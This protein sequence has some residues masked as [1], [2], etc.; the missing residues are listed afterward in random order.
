MPSP[1]MLTVMCPNCQH[2]FPAPGCCNPATLQDEEEDESNRLMA[3]E[4]TADYKDFYGGGGGGGGLGFSRGFGHGNSCFINAPTII[5][6]PIFQTGDPNPS[7]KSYLDL[8]RNPPCLLSSPL[9]GETSSATSHVKLS[10][11]GYHMITNGDHTGGGVTIT[12]PRIQSGGCLVECIDSGVL[13]QSPT[14]MRPQ[15]ATE[16]FLS[17]HQLTT[18]IHDF[19]P[20]ILDEELLRDLPSPNLVENECCCFTCKDQVVQTTP[21]GCQELPGMRSSFSCPRNQRRF[22]SSSSSQ[23][24]QRAAAAVAA[25]ASVD[26]QQV[27]QVCC[28]QNNRHTS[29]VMMVQGS[30]PDLQ[31]SVNATLQLPANL[32]QC[33]INFTASTNTLKNST[34]NSDNSSKTTNSSARSWNNFNGGGIIQPDNNY[35]MN[36]SSNL[37]NRD[38][39]TS[40]STP[41]SWLM[42][43]PWSFDTILMDKET[44]RL[45]EVK[46]MLMTTG[47]YYPELSWKQSQELVKGASV[48]SWLIRDSSDKRFTFTV[49]VQIPKGATS[50]RVHHY[51]GQFRFDAVARFATI[52]PL[53][54]CPIK[55]IEYYV[56]YSK[57][58]KEKREVWLDCN[59]G[60]RRQIYL[61]TP[62][63]KEVRSLSHLARLA[64]N[65]YQLPTYQL[66]PLIRK[67]LAEY[68]Y[69]I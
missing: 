53:F 58:K 11:T 59:S 66:P 31:L 36:G 67:Y 49:T 24:C 37:D 22:S 61:T 39:N 56:M 18:E 2:R 27:C 46:K 65:A 9:H 45:C 6:G 7:I 23:F 35:G 8:A 13:F 33:T 69:S 32:G 68:P 4:S 15:L 40:P 47:W 51:R 1:K 50:V 34:A 25:G 63:V 14:E 29:Q 41:V 55:M 52:M 10:R 21:S 3:S 19:A 62:L 57:M 17:N 30:N 64:V 42:P 48:G 5:N 20:P 44:P 43:S 38:N 28:C 54:D 26:R 12:T 60:T 16:G